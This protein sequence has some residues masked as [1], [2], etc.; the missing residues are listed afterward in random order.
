M[1]IEFIKETRLNGDVIYYTNA[2]GYYVDGSLELVET[3][4]KERFDF[5]VKTNSLSPV[6]TIIAEAIIDNK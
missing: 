1:K 5:I 2:D 4:A 6:K 3:K